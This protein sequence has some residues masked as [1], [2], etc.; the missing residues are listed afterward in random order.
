MEISKLI[1]NLRLN[2]VNEK[3]ITETVEYSKMLQQNQLPVIFDLEHLRRLLGMK[4]KDF[5]KIYYSIHNQY[6]EKFIPKNNNKGFRKLTIPSEHLKYIQ[7]WILDNILSNLKVHEKAVGF[8][9]GKS[10]VYNASYHVNKEYILKMDLKDFFPSISPKRVY[11]FFLSIGYNKN[12][13]LILT[14]FC[15]YKNGLPQGAPTSPYLSNLICTKLDNRLDSLCKKRK[16]VYTRYADDISISGGK[17]TKTT[18][19]YVQ[20]IV[21]DEGFIINHQKTVI[22]YKNKRQ[23]ITGVVVNDKLSIPKGLYRKVRQ[24]IYYM[25]KYGVTS[26]LTKIQMIRKSNVKQYYYG[27]ANYFQMIDKVKGQKILNDLK[28][29]DWNT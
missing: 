5:Y 23:S 12:L 8:S 26:H 2:G 22:V 3:D 29:I 24:E 1:E 7:R 6:E 11:G 27:L 28:R 4:K 10:T 20:K 19:N 9:V 25:E 18:S 13:S 16:L 14:D 15:T 17:K 21:E